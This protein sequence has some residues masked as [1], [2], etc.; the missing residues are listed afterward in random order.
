LSAGKETARWKAGREPIALAVTP[1][2]KQLVAANALPED[3]MSAHNSNTRNRVRIFETSSGAVTV[4][5]LFI[6]SMNARD[7][8]ITPDGRYAFV[9][10][11]IGHFDQI[12]MS[13][14]GGWICENLLAAVDLETKTFA[15]TI[16]LD[17]ASHGAANPWGI[18]ISPD[19]RFLAV[20]HAGTDEISLVNL[21][22]IIRQLDA[23]ASKTQR[24]L[25]QYLALMPHY[26]DSNASQSNDFES[27]TPVHVRIPLGVK[28]MRRIVIDDRRRIFCTAAYE[29]LIGRIDFK[30]AEP[31]QNAFN[32]PTDFGESAKPKHVLPLQ[33]IVDLPPTQ[34]KSYVVE[35]MNNLP[36]QSENNSQSVKM[37]RFTFERLE[38]LQPYSGFSVERSIARLGPPPIWNIVRR[39]E[40]LFHDGTYCEQQWLSCASCHPDGRSDAINWDLLN[41]GMNNPKNTKSLLLSHKT[42]PCMASGVRENA[43]IAVRAGVHSI[44]FSR[45]PIENDYC[46]IDEYLKSMQP[47]L[48]P[49]LVNGQFSESARR[50]KLLFNDART[51]CS[52]CH[53][54]PY[55]TDLDQHNVGTREYD[56]WNEYDTPSLVEVWRTAPY[57]HDGRY[58][59]IKELLVEGKHFAPDNRLEKLSEQEIDDLVEFVLSL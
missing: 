35:P 59:T 49:Q 41:D 42:P 12:P 9:S 6:G 18:S 28:G 14:A 13:I 11:L 39:G 22:R 45:F 38:P 24:G 5:P 55:Y 20:A 3:P 21:P 17:E 7:L 8:A 2:G 34:K 29:D 26:S 32:Y 48:S 47:T 51:G 30:I 44:L 16:Y 58:A 23:R 19:A 50:G 54:E 4:I 27:M 1:D 37:F 56:S 36:Y 33:K 46:A 25:G 40:A 10:C 53:P 43:E 57:L 15:D 52:H 31:I